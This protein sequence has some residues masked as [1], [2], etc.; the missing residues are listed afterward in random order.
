MIIYWLFW[1][2]VPGWK[3]LIINPLTGKIS[4]KNLFGVMGFYVGTVIVAVV[5][6]TE[7]ARGEKPD[8][9]I[10]GLLSLNGLGLTVAKLWQQQAN[11][12]TAT[13]EG[14]PLVAPM[15]PGYTPEAM[16]QPYN[17]NAPSAPVE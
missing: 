5:A 14:Q 10:V 12:Q 17:P 1:L 8:M 9:G 7:L 4:Q 15:P 13:P 11:R 16:P 3:D 6:L 2:I